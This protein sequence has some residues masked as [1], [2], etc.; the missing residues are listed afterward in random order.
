VVATLVACSLPASWGVIRALS[1]SIAVNAAPQRSPLDHAEEIPRQIARDLPCKTSCRVGTIV[2]H[3][4]GF[5]VTVE[6]DDV[7]GRTLLYNLRPDGGAELGFSTDWGSRMPGLIDLGAIDWSL[8]RMVVDEMNQQA[9]EGRELDNVTLRPCVPKLGST[10]GSVDKACIWAS[11]LTA[12][13]TLERSYDA[14]TG[15]IQPR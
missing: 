7:P 1:P 13:G 15:A 10:R 9:L 6:S 11:V 2:I 3:T 8:V 12:K 4:H 5:S 14:A